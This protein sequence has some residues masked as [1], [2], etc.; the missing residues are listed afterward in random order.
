MMVLVVEIRHDP[1]Q[2]L[3]T[4]LPVGNA[5][6][7]LRKEFTKFA[8]RFF[9]GFDLVVQVENLTTAQCLAQDGFFDERDTVLADEGFDREASGGRCGDNRQVPQATQCHIQC[10]RDWRRSHGQ[11]I[12]FGAKCFD[13]L[14]LFDPK[15]VLFIDD[16]EPQVAE[17]KSRFAAVC[18]CRLEYRLFRF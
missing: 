11:N 7:Q 1:L 12:D 3:F 8:G 17:L 4:Q 5:D 9:D 10:S 16:Q 18:G 15:A 13:R 6:R 2:R 14:F